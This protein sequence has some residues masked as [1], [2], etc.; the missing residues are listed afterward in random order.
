ML[1]KIT[2]GHVP[3]VVPCETTNRIMNR[4]QN[5][6]AVL[7]DPFKFI[8]NDKLTIASKVSSVPKHPVKGV[9]PV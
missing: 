6:L 5:I 9:V 7:H 4:G 3:A 2:C 8:L 1:D